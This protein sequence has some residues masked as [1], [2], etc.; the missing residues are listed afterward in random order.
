[1]LPS[2]SDDSIMW[3]LAWSPE[4]GRG[5]HRTAF[6]IITSTCATMNL[7]D[8]RAILRVGKE[9][10]KFLKC[11]PDIWTAADVGILLKIPDQIQGTSWLHWEPKLWAVKSSCICWDSRWGPGLMHLWYVFCLVFSGCYALF[12]ESTAQVPKE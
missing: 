11:V 6:L 8:R 12:A 3:P 9:L 5:R 10:Y 1:M 4:S 7:M 2:P